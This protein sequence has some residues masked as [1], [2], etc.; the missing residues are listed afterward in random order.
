MEE[1]QFIW[2]KHGVVYHLYVRSFFD[3][4]EDGIGDLQG[5]IQKFDYLKNLGVTAIWLSPIYDSP[6]KD[7][8]YD[9]VN[10]REI[11]G[12]YGNLEDF[13][14]LLALAHKNQ[15][16]IIMDLV[17]N[18]TSNQHPWFLESSSSLTN[19]KR[20]W[21]IWKSPYQLEIRFWW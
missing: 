2:W 18:H 12:S 21:Y 17:M 10:Y 13:K 8:G 4:N 11:D 9:I 3:S 14:E 7:Y 6:M 19:P 15:V 1:D 20:D 16:R 5:V